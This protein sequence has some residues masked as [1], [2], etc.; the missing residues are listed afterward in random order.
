MMENV[1][2]I[3]AAF[4]RRN[5]VPATELPALIQQVNQSLASLGQPSTAPPVSPVPAVSIRASIRPD[6]LVCLTCGQK[7]KM[8]KRHLSTAHGMTPQE[9]RAKWD[10]RNDRTELCS[11][12]VAACQVARIGSGQTAGDVVTRFRPAFTWQ[13]ATEN[14]CS[15]RVRGSG[16]KARW[17][18]SVRHA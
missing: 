18:C 7:S 10:L 4:L 17:R 12:A 9:Y 3:V 14:L 13:H 8:L 2:E 11:P 15:G 1:A 5:Q 16:R 6:H